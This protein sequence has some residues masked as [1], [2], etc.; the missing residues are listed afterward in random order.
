MDEGAAAGETALTGGRGAWERLIAAAYPDVWRLC[1]L[2]T[3]SASA[4]DLTQE[5]FLR[6]A[7]ALPR[8]KGQASAH[9]WLLAIARRTCMDELRARYRRARR[10]SLLE[11]SA[12]RDNE[13]PDHAGEVAT[14]DLLRRL[15]PDRRAAFVLTQ[16]FRLSYAQAAEVCECPTGTIRSRVA[17]AREDLVEWSGVQPTLARN[18]PGRQ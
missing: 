12:S 2:L 9:T 14:H 3:D 6:A 17:R 4:D 10:D 5:T 7:R 15:E 1:A 8:F 18:R 11:S 16:M 13:A